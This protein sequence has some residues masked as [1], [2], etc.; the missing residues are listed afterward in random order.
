VLGCY[1]R[2]VFLDVLL[3][4]ALVFVVVVCVGLFYCCAVKYGRN[5][6]ENALKQWKSLLEKYGHAGVQTYLDE[7]YQQQPGDWECGV[8]AVRAAICICRGDKAPLKVRKKSHQMKALASKYRRWMVDTA[9][10][11]FGAHT[12]RNSR[13]G[14]AERLLPRID[15]QVLPLPV[16]RLAAC[17]LWVFF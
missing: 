4:R 5:A 11:V 2:C 6:A 7:D 14:S 16:R 15:A 13:K 10:A 1:V 9:D 3:L 12:C 17:N 8:L